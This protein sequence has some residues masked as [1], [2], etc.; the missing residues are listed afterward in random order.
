MTRG[1]PTPLLELVV[2]NTRVPEPG[3]RLTKLRQASVSPELLDTFGATGL[4][5]SL[6]GA[7]QVNQNNRRA[8]GALDV[9]NIVIAR[10]RIQ[11]WVP[12]I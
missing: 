10:G 2:S 1:I 5:S 6:A 12:A 11:R 7:D 8:D 4:T 9:G 3:C